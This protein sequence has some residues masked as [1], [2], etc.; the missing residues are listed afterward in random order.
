MAII[1]ILSEL[2]R[3][4]NLMGVLTIP[5]VCICDVDFKFKLMQPNRSHLMAM[6]TSL[7]DE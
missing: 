7:F 6:Q 5:L 4:H 1:G 3:L 2:D